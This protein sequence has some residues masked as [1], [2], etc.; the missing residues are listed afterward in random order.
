MISV[1]SET[2][3]ATIPRK[4]PYPSSPAESM[5]GY[6]PHGG[7]ERP[8]SYIVLP[9][10]ET[11]V[12]WPQGDTAIESP[13]STVPSTSPRELSD[14][15]ASLCRTARYEHFEDGME[16]DFSREL[17]ATICRYGHRAVEVL[18]T[19]LFT[20]SLDDGVSS[21]AL[22]WLGLIAHG[23]SCLARRRVLEGAIFSTSARMRHGATLGLSFL[24]DPHALQYLK[25]AADAE[26]REWLRRRMLQVIAHLEKGL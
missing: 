11:H 18:E 16:S 7:P 4:W 17:T 1:E 13:D 21:E 22:R 19:L 12:S 25:R 9:S 20:G 23:P 10:F 8:P 26:A 5:T 15:M 6:D 24:N 3:T 2:G 14:H